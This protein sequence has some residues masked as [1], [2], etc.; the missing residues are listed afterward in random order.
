MEAIAWRDLVGRDVIA[1]IHLPFRSQIFILV[2]IVNCRSRPL[3]NL[4]YILAPF[5][6]SDNLLFDMGPLIFVVIKR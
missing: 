6:K 1:S 3:Q 2:Q 4:V 5:F